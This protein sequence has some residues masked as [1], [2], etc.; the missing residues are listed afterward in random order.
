MAPGRY[1]DGQGKFHVH[2]R[3]QSYLLRTNFVENDP[4]LLWQY[5]IQ[6]VAMEQAFKNLK[7]DLAIRPIFHHD[8]RRIEAHIFIAFL[9]YCLQITLQR[10]LHSPAPGLTARSA[11]EKFAA[12]QMIDVHQ[13]PPQPPRIATANVPSQLL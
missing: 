4:V 1:R 3:A 7:G 8:E 9:A 5:Y 6:L 13:L 2:L 11:I 10:R 12:V